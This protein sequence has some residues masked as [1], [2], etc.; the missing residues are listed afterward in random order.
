M[1][2]NNVTVAAANLTIF[3]NTGTSTIFVFNAAGSLR[4]ANTIVAHDFGAQCFTSIVGGAVASGGHN[5][6]S[7]TDS[8]FTASGDIQNGVADL[9]ALAFNGDWRRCG[10][11][12]SSQAVD[13]GDNA[14]L[15]L[16]SCR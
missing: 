8:S 13:A 1:Y 6:D 12:S 9:S 10:A 11:G 7:G 14:M 2:I 15:R 4:I 3:G 16:R 5:I